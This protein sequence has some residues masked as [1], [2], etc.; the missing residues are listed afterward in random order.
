[1]LATHSV[2]SPKAVFALGALLILS[3]C[4][5]DA[6]VAP[7]ARNLVSDLNTASVETTTK[8]ENDGF[9]LRV[10][11]QI[12]GEGGALQSLS[13]KTEDFA[14]SET[15]YLGQTLS[16][17]P[18]ADQAC[19]EW[20][21]D[22]VAQ[23]VKVELQCTA[24]S[25]DSS[26]VT[27]SGQAEVY[28]GQTATLQHLG[29]KQLSQYQVSD[30]SIKSTKL[31]ALKEMASGAF[32]NSTKRSLVVTRVVGTSIQT[33][34]ASAVLTKPQDP[35]APVTT[36]GIYAQTDR[37]G[38]HTESKFFTRTVAQ[39]QLVSDDNTPARI[40]IRWFPSQGQLELHIQDASAFPEPE[41]EDG[42]KLVIGYTSHKL[43]APPLTGIDGRAP[44]W[45]IE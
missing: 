42:G 32:S 23:P 10:S 25:C 37:A 13:F 12:E 16:T 9:A 5:E 27:V 36:I 20:A 11:L 40:Q 17:K 41:R 34:R 39:G 21:S 2:R 14:G 45:L 28:Q 33:V 35:A 29:F 6:P 38:K 31:Q 18:C 24:G 4:G 7:A 15:M 3:A 26:I 43:V 8:L 44:F 1:M 22:S 30:V 19:A